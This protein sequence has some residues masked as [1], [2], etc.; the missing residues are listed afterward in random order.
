[1]PSPLTVI[2]APNG[3][4]NDIYGEIEDGCLYTMMFKTIADRVGQYLNADNWAAA[5]NNFGPIDDMSTIYASIHKGKYD[6][7]D[8]YGL[9]AYD[10]T[11]GDAGDWKQLTPVQ[12]RRRRVNPSSRVAYAFDVALRWRGRRCRGTTRRPAGRCAPRSGVPPAMT[13]PASRQ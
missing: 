10:P 12:R 9:V 4:Q 1:M 3:K 6:A 5:V 11:I 8:T 13:A 7:D 2:K